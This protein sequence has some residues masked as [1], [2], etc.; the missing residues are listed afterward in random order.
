MSLSG[1]VR[2]LHGHISQF[3]AGEDRK[4]HDSSHLL[5]SDSAH[6]CNRTSQLYQAPHSKVTSALTLLRHAFHWIFAE[7]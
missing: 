2:E 5:P 1:C 7:D 6:S 4:L 3:R